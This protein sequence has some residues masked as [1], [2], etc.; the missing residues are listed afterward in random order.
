MEST[1]KKEATNNCELILTNKTIGDSPYNNLNYEISCT[2]LFFFVH[3]VLVVVLV[4][5]LL[6]CSISSWGT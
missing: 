3:T 5:N 1:N 6:N 2:V 4:C